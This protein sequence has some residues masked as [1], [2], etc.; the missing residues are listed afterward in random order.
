MAY[1]SEYS[2]HLNGGGGVVSVAEVVSLV[3]EA[4]AQVLAIR[5][6]AGGSSTDVLIHRLYPSIRT[7]HKELGVK[8]TLHSQNDAIGATNTHSHSA[9]SASTSS[10]QQTRTHPEA[11]TALL[12]YS[13][14]NKRPS[15]E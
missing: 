9:R 12:A 14:W 6:K 13:T 7:L 8:K 2:T 15:G 3:A 10:S 1:V 5:K 11:S 4:A